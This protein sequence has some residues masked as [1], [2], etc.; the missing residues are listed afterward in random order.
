[1]SISRTHEEYLQ[2]LRDND[3]RRFVLYEANEGTGEAGY[4]EI[5]KNP[6]GVGEIGLAE[7]TERQKRGR[8]RRSITL[9]RT[10]RK[11]KPYTW[12]LGYNA[13][14][15]Q[16][17]GGNDPAILSGSSLN[18]KQTEN[19]VV[20][21][22]R[23]GIMYKPKPAKKSDAPAVH[24]M[25]KR[26]KGK[27]RDKATAFFRA[28]KERKFLTLTFI[29]H[30]SDQEGRKIL[31]KF[32][33]VVRKDIP[34]FHNLNVAEHQPDRD[35]HT[36]HFHILTNRRIC[37][38]RFNALWVLQ[39]YNS[40]LIGH[41]AN[42]E[43]IGM[44]EIADRYND[45][46]IGQVLNPAQI[47]N[48]YSISL[49]A[50]YLTKYV[51]KQQTDEKFGCLT[52]HCSRK[53]SRLFTSQIVGPSA[54]AFLQSFRNWKLDRSTGKMWKPQQIDGAFYK[55]IFV[56]NKPVVLDN[57]QMMETANGWIMEGMPTDRRWGEMRIKHGDYKRMY[58][59][60]EQR[61]DPAGIVGDII[62]RKNLYDGQQKKTK[63]ENAP[64]SSGC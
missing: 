32:L 44:G 34:G 37:I 16:Y 23:G 19:F 55:V 35:T 54:F 20:L 6:Y 48:A 31:N 12:R 13:C 39:Q 27:I 14:T 36:I 64:A 51:T 42:G 25:S 40:G 38:R 11:V 4:L 62:S 45:G 3:G 22:K 30:V 28:V 33:T 5:P 17:T 21:A 7:P 57:L 50:W 63:K 43:A 47:E 10:Q 52:W 41:R 49:L 58:I 18:R 56:N 59:G 24:V 61:F 29:E 1:M 9:Q 26:T 8:K 53:V 60:K 2:S 15:A 46:T